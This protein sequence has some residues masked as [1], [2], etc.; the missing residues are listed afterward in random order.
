MGF[1]SDIE[2]PL[3]IM[4]LGPSKA[5]RRKSSSQNDFGFSGLH[6][7]DAAPGKKASR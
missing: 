1:R 6:K 2:T 5:A 7:L 4:I 3:R